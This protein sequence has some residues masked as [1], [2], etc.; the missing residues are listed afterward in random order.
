[1]ELVTGWTPKSFSGAGNHFHCDTLE[2]GRG[3]RPTQV[4]PLHFIMKYILLSTFVFKYDQEFLGIADQTYL[5]PQGGFIFLFFNF[6][7][8]YCTFCFVVVFYTQN[9]TICLFLINTCHH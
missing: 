2:L 4:N 9:R 5:C 3:V 6:G 8:Q 7:F 1:M